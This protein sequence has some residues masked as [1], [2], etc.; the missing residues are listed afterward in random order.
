MENELINSA[1]LFLSLLYL[2]FAIISLLLIIKLIRSKDSLY[3]ISYFFY[4][5]LLLTTIFRT[6][7]LIIISFKNDDVQNSIFLFNILVL[8]PDMLF[9]CFFFI[10]V[11][12]ALIHYIVSHINVE[13]D[14]NLYLSTNDDD[15]KIK[16]KFIMFYILLCLF[17]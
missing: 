4:S 12:H 3:N 14:T 7:N 5:G 16:K 1:L 13:N 8:L 15:P 9:T 17:I 2:F 11:W 6:I 10:L